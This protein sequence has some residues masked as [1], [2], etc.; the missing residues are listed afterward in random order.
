[1]IDDRPVIDRARC[2][3]DGRCISSCPVG[4]WQERRRGFLLYVG[5]KVG[6]NPRLG[7]VIDELIP[8]SRVVKAVEKVLVVFGDLGKK[9][10]RIA[11]TIDRVGFEEFSDRYR[12]P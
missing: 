11:D 1:M 12:S 6:R 7:Q 3:L 4:A 10:E 9:G 8:E 5:G 2:L